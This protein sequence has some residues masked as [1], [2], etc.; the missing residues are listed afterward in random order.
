MPW[1]DEIERLEKEISSLKNENNNLKQKVDSSIPRRRIRRV[2]KQLKKILEQDISSENEAYIN[3]L[4]AIVSQYRNGEYVVSMHINESLIVAI[5]H[6]L[7]LIEAQ[8]ND[9]DE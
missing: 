3:Y 5:E 2:Y 7:G 1:E 4:K 9:E 8:E 6:C